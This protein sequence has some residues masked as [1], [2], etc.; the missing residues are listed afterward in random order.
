M[1]R[2]S[3][4][5]VLE[6]DAA[7]RTVVGQ[8]MRRAGHRVTSAQSLAEPDAA[9]AAGLPDVLITDVVLPDG[10]GLERVGELSARA[11]S[12][13]VIV[14]SAQNTLST[15]VRANEAGEFE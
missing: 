6:D 4:V 11:P 2:Q 1:T 7:I 9:L 14:L 12:L 5:L 15:A 3:H 10:D 8:A 13:P